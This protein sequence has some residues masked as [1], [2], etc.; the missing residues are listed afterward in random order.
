MD[1]TPI[2]QLSGLRHEYDAHGLRRSDLHS[3]P[4]EQFRAWFAAAIA[5]TSGT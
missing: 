3:D 5:E 2:P 1:D 4:F